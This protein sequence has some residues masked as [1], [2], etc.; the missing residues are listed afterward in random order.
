MS[1]GRLAT[2]H[3]VVRSTGFHKYGYVF[4]KLLPLGKGRF[5]ACFN[6]GQV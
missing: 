2:G 6:G 5:R 1:E 4:G 3:R